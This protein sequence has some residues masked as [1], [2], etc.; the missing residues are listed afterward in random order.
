M[1]LNE[2]FISQLKALT[3]FKIE[4]S[5][6]SSTVIKIV[7][8]SICN[9]D[10]TNANVAQSKTFNFMDSFRPVY[11]VSRIFGLMPFSIICDINGEI[12]QSKITKFDGLWFVFSMCFHSLM[13]FF[14][15]GF[16]ETKLNY[17]LGYVFEIFGITY[18]VL[19]L[20]FNMYNRSKFIDII[21]EI[22]AFDIEVSNL[23]L[24]QFSISR[25]ITFFVFIS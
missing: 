21:R 11:Y 3:K 19:S 1:D 14:V 13:A 5:D 25:K 24:S 18:C 8:P 16:I 23:L 2:N 4:K 6:S 10:E 7:K 15:Q 12:Q 9:H 20:A 22:T 17:L